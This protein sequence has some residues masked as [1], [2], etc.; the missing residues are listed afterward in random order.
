[1]PSTLYLAALALSSISTSLAFDDISIASTV[2]AGTDV[3]VTI[4]NDISSSSSSSSSSSLRGS[5]SFDAGFT[6][7]RV[8]LSISPPGT[9]YGP[10]CYL[11]N[12]TSIST[13]TVT[14]NIPASV[15]PSGP[16]DSPYAIVT[17]EFNDDPSAPSS[18]SSFEYSNDFVLEGGTGVWTDY[19]KD[20]MSVGDPDNLPCTAYD[21]ARQCSQ[22]YYPQ[23]SQDQLTD[24]MEGYRST[25]EC[26]AACPGVTYQSWD[27]VMGGA[28]G[29]G[30]GEDNSTSS[31]SSSIGSATKTGSAAGGATGGA[32]KGNSSSTTTTATSSGSTASNT[33]GSSAASVV[34][35]KT[36][37]LLAGF[38][39]L[40]AF[41]WL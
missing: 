30:D 39:A 8:Y 5:D 31:S 15:G 27:E 11:I 12:S 13:E 35:E 10:S 20:Q 36:A 22:K 41:V 9:G 7:F 29:E 32:G 17:A 19:E 3:P 18:L 2:Q 6:S 33:A 23:N 37:L 28:G 1:M 38:F 24:T 26:Q 21:C 14:V 25:Y 16:D 4:T 40:A 34:V